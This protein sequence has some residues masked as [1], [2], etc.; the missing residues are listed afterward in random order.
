MAFTWRWPLIILLVGLLPCLARPSW[1]ESEEVTDPGDPTDTAFAALLSMPGAQAREGGWIIPEA[2]G[3]APAD[4]NALIARLRALKRDGAD[5]NALRHRGTLLAHAIR[6]GRQRT[7]IWLLRNGASPRRVQFSEPTTAYDLARRYRR[8]AVIQVLEDHYGFKPSAAVVPVPSTAI[9]APAVETAPFGSSAKERALALLA[10]P[11]SAPYP[12]EAEQREWQD[13]SATLSRGD[14]A[15]IFKGG[16]HLNDL[17]L[18]V[19]GTEGGLEEA[20]SRLPV[21]VVRSHAQEIADLVA[22]WS[23]ATYQDNPKISYTPAAR[24]WPAL[25]SRI[26]QPLR[27]EQWPGFAGRLPPTLWPALFASGYAEHD[28]EATGCL[29]SAVDV[30]EFKAL[31]P[32]FLRYFDNAR[33]LAPALV[34]AKYRLARERSPCYYG[35][36]RADTVA[37]LDFLRKLGVTGPVTGLRQSILDEED[38]PALAAM[39]AKF[40]PTRQAAPRLVALAPQCELALDDLWLNALVNLGGVGQGIP[41]EDVRVIDVPEQRQCGLLIGWT[42]A[43]EYADV[44]DSLDDGPIRMGSTRCADLPDDGQVWVRRADRIRVIAA[45]LHSNNG[46]NLSSEVRDTQTG[47]HYWL[48]AGKRG[49]RCSPSWSLPDA[50]EWQKSADGLALLPSPDAPLIDRLLREQCQDTPGQ[51]YLTCRGIDSANADESGTSMNDKDVLPALREGK[52][53]PFDKLVHVLGTE[54]RRAYGATIAAHDH[55]RNRALLAAGV[56][57]RWT[58]AE[59]RALGT[60]DLPLEEK[61][62][63]IALLFA[64]ATQLDRALNSNDRYDV[65]ESL[66]AWLPEEDW[67]PVLRA[68]GRSPDLWRDAAASLRQK[69][70][71]AQRSGLACAID[72]AQEFLC[73]GGIV[74]E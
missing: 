6:A 42:Q 29:L 17:V 4:E 59:I 8:A 71:A 32:D 34:L 54:R 50:F 60:A 52:F 10:K 25:W 48:N 21:E 24:A 36:S 22:P 61:R 38:D 14:F 37:K 40:A 53:V 65:P 57:P 5:F 20:L 27:Y 31:W 62:R 45:D 3:R 56:S 7:A 11:L 49:A 35:S 18:L 55:A 72:R 44:E 41:A 26:D 73:G 2:Y 64:N 15:A 33:D 1:A 9:A 74:P 70:I 69:A 66:L 63:R 13:I 58:A 16:A 46:G 51:E 47:K 30:A 68:I 28:A 23:F 67:G 39:V 43:E 19:R 12:S